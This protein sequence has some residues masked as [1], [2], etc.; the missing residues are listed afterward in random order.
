MM[1]H[2]LCSTL[3]VPNVGIHYTSVCVM[4]PTIKPHV[5]CWHLYP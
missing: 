3:I 1:S 4:Y 2:C 5:K